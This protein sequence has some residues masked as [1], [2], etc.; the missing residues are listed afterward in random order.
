V[1]LAITSIG[2]GTAYADTP[3]GAAAGSVAAQNSPF[4]PPPPPPHRFRSRFHTQ[5]QCEASAGHDH[6]G[7]R[8][9]WD[10]R[11]GPDRNNPWEYWGA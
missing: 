11:R 2:V 9:D 1:A 7:R 4:R 8:G 5:Q 10:C 6:P 3:A